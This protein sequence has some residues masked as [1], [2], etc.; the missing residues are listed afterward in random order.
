MA[1]AGTPSA[2]GSP[3]V[4]VLGTLHLATSCKQDMRRTFQDGGFRTEV[5][6]CFSEFAP[7]QMRVFEGLKDGWSLR[8]RCWKRG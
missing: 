4:R 3:H 1:L 5:S 7:Q 2:P 8:T 6:G